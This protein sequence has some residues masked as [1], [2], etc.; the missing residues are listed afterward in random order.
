[1][2]PLETRLK[3]QHPTYYLLLVKLLFYVYFGCSAVWEVID[4][5]I[6]KLSK[7]KFKKET[8]KQFAGILLAN[9][10]F[11]QFFSILY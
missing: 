5:Q 8:E 9:F 4:E 6:K 3:I 1:M 11:S 2:M 7:A 10:N